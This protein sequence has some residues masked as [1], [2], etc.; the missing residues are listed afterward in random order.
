M[1]GSSTF[2][3]V[4]R[5]LDHGR[6]ASFDNLLFVAACTTA[7]YALIAREAFNCAARTSFDFTTFRSGCVRAAGHIP[8]SAQVARLA[9]LRTLM[10]TIQADLVLFAECDALRQRQIVRPVD[11]IRL[12][13]HVGLPRIRTGFAP[14]AGFFFAAERAADFRA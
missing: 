7:Y 12:A 14:A 2:L 11:G 9:P 8:R 13:A 1:F 6:D 5:R 3:N 10:N 4:T